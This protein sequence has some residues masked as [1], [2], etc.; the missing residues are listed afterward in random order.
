MIDE[1][2]PAPL[3]LLSVSGYENRSN[4]LLYCAPRLQNDRQTVVYFGGDIQDFDENMKSHRDN[5][6]Y[7]NWSLDS[8][9]LIL[10]AAFPDSHVVVVRPSRMEYKTFS[11]FENFVP[12]GNCGVPEHT[13]MHHSL[14]HL[15]RL[16]ESVAA[17]AKTPANERGLTLVGFS[18]GCVVLNQF[19]YEFHA[20]GS[21]NG[22]IS[23]IKDMYWLDGGHSGGKNTWV[24]SK[25][26]LET[27]AGFGI[28]VHV[29]VSPY[30]IQDDRRPWIRREEKIFYNTLCNFKAPIQRHVHCPDLPPSIFQHFSI[31]NEFHKRDSISDGP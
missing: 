26:L 2:N 31:L 11:C 21:K 20:L 9:A 17:Q 5:K 27:L 13:P 19:L 1:D 23:R 6:N 29:H 22:I 28:N 30:Q 12:S 18:K 14:E 4:D 10:R 24:T 15:E 8:T 7:T 25:S 3:K 16:L